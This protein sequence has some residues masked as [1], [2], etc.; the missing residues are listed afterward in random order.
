MR[1]VS[2]RTLPRLACRLPS[3]AVIC[4]MFSRVFFSAAI[5]RGNSSVVSPRS[6]GRSARSSSGGSCRFDVNTRIFE[7][8]TSERS[9]VKMLVV[10]SQRASSSGT[11]MTIRALPSSR[12]TM[13]RTRPIE[14]PENVRSMPTLTPSALSTTSVRRCV[15]SNTP[16]AYI[17]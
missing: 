5:M 12:S 6:T 13:R 9:S 11:S 17:T 15:G 16:R 4:S 8:P 1:S 7:L 10:R 2:V 14:K 3:V